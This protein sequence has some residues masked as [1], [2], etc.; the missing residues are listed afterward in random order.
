MEETKKITIS[1]P[2]KSY[3]LFNRLSEKFGL[4]KSALISYWIMENAKAYDV[5]NR[6]GTITKGEGKDG[7]LKW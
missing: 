4:K 7:C 1:I 3:D 5:I 6:P 2:Y